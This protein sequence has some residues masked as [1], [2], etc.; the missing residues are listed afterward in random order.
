MKRTPLLVGAALA[1]A[2]GLE[3]GSAYAFFTASGSGSTAATAGTAQAVTVVAANGTPSSTLSPG[4]SADLLVE[5]DD[6]NSYS[7]IITSISENGTTVTPVGGSGCTTANNG[8]SVPALSGLSIT[9]PSGTN[10]VVDVP[11]SVAMSASSASGCQGASFQ[12][13]VNLTVQR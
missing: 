2:I 11:N 13:P 4:G 10:V 3:G 1:L 9:V 5:L 7:V 6:P 8:V 12:I